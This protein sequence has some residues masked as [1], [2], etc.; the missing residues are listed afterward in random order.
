MKDF[1]I[2]RAM[3]VARKET[4]HVVRDARSLVMAIALPMILLL[5]FGYA[6]TLDVDRVPLLVWDRSMTPQSRELVSRFNGSRYF[7][8]R[9]SV[10]SYREI[11]E[12]IDRRHTLAALVVPDDF[13]SSLAAGR[14][15]DLQFIVDGSDANTSILATGYAEALT[16]AYSQKLSLD[17]LMKRTGR[18]LT[19]PLNV[20]SR[21]WFNTDMESKNFIVPSLIAVVMMIIAALLTSLTVSREWERGTMEQLISTPVTA[22]EIIIGKLAPYFAIGMIDVTIS[23]LMGEFLFH[24]PL[25]G[26]VALLFA[27]ASIYLAGALSMGIL[28]SVA[29]R[30]QLL[31]TQIAMIGTFLPAFLLSGFMFAISNMPAFLQ[32]VTYLVPARY[33]IIVIRGIYLKGVGLEIIGFEAILLT[34]FGF[35]TV[36]LANVKFKKRLD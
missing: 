23:V 20:N 27:M 29:T 7:S 4:L 30:N 22:N 34:I 19:Q 32:V 21:V 31:S 9:G 8:I 25:R 5:L 26:S 36:L 33:F 35:V 17:F 2:S 16:Q 15:S 3:A 12:A 1:S 14:Q 24:V 11:E 28:I 10:S 18:K 6:L 13:A